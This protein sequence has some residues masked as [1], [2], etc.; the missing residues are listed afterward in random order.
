MKDFIS[1]TGAAVLGAVFFGASAQALPRVFSPAMS[2]AAVAG[3]VSSHGAA[4]V[5]TGPFTYDRY[6]DS[7]R[8][9]TRN[10]DVQPAWVQAADTPY[11]FIGYT[12]GWG[13]SN[14]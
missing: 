11:C 6:V 14:D 7:G 12:C 9:C 8:F 10:K 4:L 13:R 5:Q 1:A 2:C 3:Y